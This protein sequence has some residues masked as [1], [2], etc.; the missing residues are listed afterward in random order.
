MSKVN[1]GL[2]SSASDDWPTPDDL[3]ATLNGEFRFTLDACASAANAK[4]ARFYSRTDNGLA[5]PWYG[6]VWC[7]PPYGRQ[8]G[9]WVA[10]ARQASE[11]GATVVMLIPARTDTAYWHD[12]AMRAA[13]IRFICGRLNFAGERQ[14]ARLEAGES[15][16]HNAPFPSAL[17]IFRP[18]I[19]S[20]VVSGCDRSGRPVTASPFNQDDLFSEVTG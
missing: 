15:V 7:N 12:H 19:S 16:A 5:Q 11:A 10:K 14:A 3:F 20:P 1:D 13:E 4:C 8:I 6:R 17:L 2:F 18:G 9:A